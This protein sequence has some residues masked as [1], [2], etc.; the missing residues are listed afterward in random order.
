MRDPKN[1]NIRYKFA[2]QE[3]QEL[4]PEREDE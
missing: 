2:A 3:N 1:L 4:L